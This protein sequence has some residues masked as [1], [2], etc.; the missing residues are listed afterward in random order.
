LATSGGADGGGV[1][2][3]VVEGFA[4][5]LDEVGPT[6]KVN[7]FATAWGALEVNFTGIPRRLLRAAAARVSRRVFCSG[8]TL[9]AACQKSRTPRRE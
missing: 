9:L 7:R 4:D 5:L 6:V 2:G 8:D 3:G 1:F